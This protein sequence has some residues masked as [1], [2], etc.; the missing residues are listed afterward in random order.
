MKSFDEISAEAFCDLLRKYGQPESLKG[1]LKQSVRSSQQASN[2]RKSGARTKR[3][4][5]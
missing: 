2:R 4:R 1:A 3:K 5:K